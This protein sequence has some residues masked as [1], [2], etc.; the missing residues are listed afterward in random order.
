MSTYGGL[1]AAIDLDQS[2]TLGEWRIPQWMEF[3]ESYRE[4]YDQDHELGGNSAARIWGLTTH[5]GQ[6]AVLFTANPTNVI[7]Y[8]LVST[9]GALLGMI[10]EAT[11][12][13]SNIHALFVPNTGENGGHSPRKK[14]GKVIAHVLSTLDQGGEMDHEAQKLLYSAACCAIADG[15][16]EQIRN[17]AYEAL[18][19]LATI[20]G[21]DLGEEMSKCNFLSSEILAPGRDRL[22][23]PGGHLFERCEVCDAGFIWDL[24]KEA[25]CENGHLFGVFHELVPKVMGNAN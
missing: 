21:A 4:E 5:R 3:V 23:G 13:P 20:T 17:E 12:D 10:D 15:Q 9:E 19:R 22:E 1:G 25:Q 6:T 24:A 8:R 18:K 7:E 11:G 16:T 14:R 2:G